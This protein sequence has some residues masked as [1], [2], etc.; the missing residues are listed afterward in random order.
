MEYDKKNGN[1][2]FRESDHVYFNLKDADKKY[3]SVTTLIHK[4]TQEFDK[5]FWSSY[6]SLQFLIPAE[7]FKLE[8]GRLLETKKID[9]E[10]MCKAYDIDIKEFES[11][12]QS[13][14]DEWSKANSDACIRGTALHK[15]MEDLVYDNPDT[16]VR[17]YGF[18]GKFQI[19]KDYSDLDLKYGLY[20]EYLIYNDEMG[21][22][23]QIDLLIK[24]DND[25]TLIDHKSNSIKMESGYDPSIKKRTMMQYPLNNLMD[26]NFYH[27][28]LQLSTYAYML[29]KINPNFNIKRLALN[30]ISEN[31]CGELIDCQYLRKEVELMVKDYNKKLVK[32]TIKDKYKP[33][34]F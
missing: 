2:A 23:G 10:N 11:K 20:P 21:L 27:Y 5:D 8:K 22:A 28:S 32:Q 19:K 31:G 24:D 30:P 3:T 7:Y 14:L 18:G 34:K 1:V 17:K 33:I 25:I 9:I 16:I 4:Y 13:I 6:K 15:Q 12:R 26:C 29:Q